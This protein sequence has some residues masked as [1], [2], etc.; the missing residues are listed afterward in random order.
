MAKAYYSLVLDHPADRV[1]SVIRPFDHY[2]WAGVVAETVIED[3]RRGDQVGSVRRVTYRGQTLRQKLLA[4]SDAGRSYTYAFC[5]EPPFPVQH[6][7]A[8]I[9]VS[10]VVEMN[11][12]FV[13]WWATFDCAADDRGRMIDQ[14]ERSGFAVWLGALR[15]FMAEADDPTVTPRPDTA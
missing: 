8:T 14:F 12:A 6:Y 9:R 2:A 13:E 7:E 11:A 1:W 10:P 3:G 5:G 15:R 4:H